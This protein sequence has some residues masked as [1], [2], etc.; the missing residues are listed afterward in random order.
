MD[1][2]INEGCLCR[3]FLIGGIAWR[4]GATSHSSSTQGSCTKGGVLMESCGTR[5]S[6]KMRGIR[7]TLHTNAAPIGSGQ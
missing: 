2:T 1:A 4:S 7:L 6:K 5:M 3:K